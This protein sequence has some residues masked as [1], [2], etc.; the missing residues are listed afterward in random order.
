MHCSFS[1]GS[2]GPEHSGCN[3]NVIMGILCS[4][5]KM[6]QGQWAGVGRNNYF[7][8][9]YYNKKQ[10]Q[11]PQT[12]TAYKDSNKLWYLKGQFYVNLTFLFCFNVI[13][14]SKTYVECHFDSV[15]HVLDVLEFPMATIQC[16]KTR[17]VHDTVPL[18]PRGWYWLLIVDV[19]LLQLSISFKH[20]AAILDFL[21][22]ERPLILKI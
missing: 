2:S 18:I 15:M 4:L 19:S 8:I 16:S 6:N 9:F 5:L 20:L 7:Y 3:V 10:K 11:C 21:E 13:P 17:V 22:K 12:K 14:A 1:S